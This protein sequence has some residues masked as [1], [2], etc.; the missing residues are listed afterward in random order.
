MREEP[1]VERFVAD[2]IRDTDELKSRQLLGKDSLLSY[3]TSSANQYDITD[4]L[5]IGG[6]QSYRVTFDHANARG[7]AILRLDAYYRLDNSDVMALPV[8]RKPPTNPHVTVRWYKE[9]AGDTVTTWIVTLE[10]ISFTLDPVA[11]VK[12]FIT[13]T[14]AGSM[15]VAAA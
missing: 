6:E 15:S 7:G 14:D 10:N 4:Q 5:G 8:L 9:N 13:G 2:L 12:L 1:N 3:Q 11:Y